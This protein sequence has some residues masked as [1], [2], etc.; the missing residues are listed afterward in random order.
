[1]TE[2]REIAEQAEEIVDGLYH[3]QIH[4]ANIGGAI[5]SSHALVEGDACVLVDPVRLADDALAA[6]P[7]PGA[8]VL[9]ARCHQRAA[10]RYRREFGAEVWLPVDAAA[11]DEEPD[12][13]YAAGD[14]LPGG[15]VALRTPGPEWPHY[16]FLRAAEPG[17]L[18]CSD[19][20]SHGGGGELHFVPPEYHEDPA[21][22]RR[23]VERLLEL[24]FAILCFDHGGPLVDDPKA[25][26]RRLLASS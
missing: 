5:S 16:S 25:A 21:E 26:L 23:S 3:W 14:T 18:F 15:L 11:A 13:R 22:T 19:L 10:W 4:N 2:P 24:P 8:I 17:V 20:I 1:M 6:L 9:T 7:K 12:R